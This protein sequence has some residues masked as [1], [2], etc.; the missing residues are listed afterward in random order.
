MS[1]N[2]KMIPVNKSVVFFSPVEG[3]DVLVRTGTIKEGSSFLH[4]VLHA[5]SKE[6]TIMDR[7]DRMK[8]ERKL[9]ASMSGKIDKETWEEMGGGNIAQVPF[10]KN[11]NDIL[12]NFYEFVLGSDSKV[13]GRSSRRVI[14]SLIKDTKDMENYKLMTELISLKNFKPKKNCTGISEY[15]L[16]LKKDTLKF[17]HILDSIDEDKAEYI[18]NMI[19]TFIDLVTKEAEDSAFKDYV[20]GLENIGADVDS[21]TVEFISDRFN[22]NIYFLDGKTRLPYTIDDVPKINGVK[23]I[24]VICID[25]SHY[26]VVGRLLP[27]NKIQREFSADDTLINSFTK[28]DS[29]HSDNDD[30]HSDKSHNSDKSHSVKSHNSDKSH[31][32]AKSHNSD[33][34]YDD[35]DSHSSISE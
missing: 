28:A 33:P 15:K 30:N 25:N 9:R 20:T 10:M 31:N 18:K 16:S 4:A 32:S 2:L 17:L 34:Y 24:I 22:R 23:S 12:N 1:H 8:F 14:K 27:G 6:Y 7:K 26:E 19:Y 11:V 29:Q 3:D 5:Y 13:R 35:S 21:F